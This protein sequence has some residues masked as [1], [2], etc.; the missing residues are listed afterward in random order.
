MAQTQ[1]NAGLDA[2]TKAR[3][4]ELRKVETAV[5]EAG[6]ARDTVAAHERTAEVAKLRVAQIDAAIATLERADLAKAAKTAE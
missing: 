3:E 4:D 1:K 2:L 5:K 6:L